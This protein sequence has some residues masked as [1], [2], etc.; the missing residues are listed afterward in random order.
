[1]SPSEKYTLP[2]SESADVLSGTAYRTIGVLG[3]GGMG[4]VL[5][6]EHTAL[7]RR[8]V[9]KVVRGDTTVPQGED[10]LRLEAQALARLEH[11]HLVRVLDFGVTRSDRPSPG[12]GP[13]RVVLRV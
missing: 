3:Q 1:M 10:R 2:S 6:A 12:T 7:A 9:V 5:D 13:N 4:Q 8:V 11:P